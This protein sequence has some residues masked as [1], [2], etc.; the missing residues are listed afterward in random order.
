MA[1]EPHCRAT[2]IG[3]MPHTDP[4]VACDII[5]KAIPEIP[6]WPQLPATNFRENM[7]IQYSEGFP[8]VVLDEEKKRMYFETDRDVTSDFEKF[9]ENYMAENL[10]YF[11]IS[12]SFSRGIYE[13]EK[14]LSKNM[15]PDLATFKSHVTGP[16][17]IGLG[18]VD[19]DKR[20]IYYNELFRDILV[21][22]TEMKA[23]W[24]LNK[25]KFLECEQLCFIDEPILSGFG[26]S[27]YVSVHRKDVVE[28][29]NEVIQAIH[30][31]KC[32]AGIHCCGNTEWTILMDAGVD[33]IS[34]DAYDYADTIAY[35]PGQLK[36]FLEKGGVLA[37]GIVPTSEKID[38][39]TPE[40]LANKLKN[41]IDTLAFKGLDRQ[42]IWER[43]LITPSCGTGSLP[44]NRSEKIF[45]QLSEVSRI[46]RGSI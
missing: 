6:I 22:G 1:F 3:S 43:C 34:F 15:P 24:L 10:D 36:N 31:E 30:K 45:E 38:L 21:K 42:L 5:L 8:C 13:M 35:Y 41:S 27:T 28:Y 40:S 23:R 7:E 39:E 44:V 32:T 12:P 26:S 17:T 18:R 19:Q 4:S 46:I 37:W 20:A 16:I 11:K 2:A 14:R 29:L 33:I 25:F 9:Y